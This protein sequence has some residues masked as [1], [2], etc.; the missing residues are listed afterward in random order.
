MIAKKL[1]ENIKKD[2]KNNKVPIFVNA[3]MGTTVLGAIDPIKD[4]SEI[5][6]KYNIWLH[7]D[8]A[9]LGTLIFSKSFKNLNIYT[10]QIPF[11]L[12]HIRH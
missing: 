2:I 5:C 4:I 1:E 10:S 12:T 9:Y 11:V 8:G 6:K 7:I 3:T